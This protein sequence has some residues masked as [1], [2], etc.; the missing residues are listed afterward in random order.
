VR[1]AGVGVNGEKEVPGEIL[2]CEWPDLKILMCILASVRIYLSFVLSELGRILLVV[3]SRLEVGAHS[4]ILKV[5]L[6]RFG[7]RSG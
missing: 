7:E 1:R 5:Q 3:H 4:Y 2:C 6:A